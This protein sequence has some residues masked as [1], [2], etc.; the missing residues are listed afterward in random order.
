[1]IGVL[2]LK[3]RAS[4][5]TDV[6]LTSQFFRIILAMESLNNNIGNVDKKMLKFG[7]SED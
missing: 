2:R 1:M 6:E 7:K 4:I 3:F 5:L